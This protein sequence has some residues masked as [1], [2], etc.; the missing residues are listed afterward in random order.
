M[1][2]KRP[3]LK[4]CTCYP[5]I[6]TFWMEKVCPRQSRRRWSLGLLSPV[7]LLAFYFHSDLADPAVTHN[8]WMRTEDYWIC[9]TLLQSLSCVYRGSPNSFCWIPLVPTEKQ[10]EFAC[11]MEPDSAVE[12]RWQMLEMQTTVMHLSLWFP[13][14]GKKY[15]QLFAEW[16]RG[17]KDKKPLLATRG[18]IK[19]VGVKVQDIRPLFFRYHL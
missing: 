15:K 7:S 9:P 2:N 13:T 14:K 11:E 12:R 17:N 8:W 6:D 18:S 5:G 4:K 1:E 3:F 19:L 16:P 10:I